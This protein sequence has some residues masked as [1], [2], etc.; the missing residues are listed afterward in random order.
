MN[1]IHHFVE[2]EYFE[3]FKDKEEYFPAG[4]SAEGFIHCTRE[5]ENVVK[6]ADFM[7]GGSKSDLLLLVIDEDR[8]KPEIKYESAGSET[9]FPHIYGGLNM[10]AV[11]EVM[12]FTKDE[13]GKFIFPM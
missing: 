11:V 4:F 6:V 13:K 8:V 10:D 3:K 1:I 9:L 7:M 2:K 12:P 5:P